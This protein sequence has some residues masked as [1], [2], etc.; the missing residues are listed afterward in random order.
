MLEPLNVKFIVDPLNGTIPTRATSESAA[1]DFYASHD[2]TIP[3]FGRAAIGT[4][5]TVCWNN[6]NAYLQLFSRSGLF[7]NFGITCEGGVIDYDFQQP[8][9]VL[10][11]NNTADCYEVKKGDRI[12]QGIFLPICPVERYIYV[13]DG[14]GY[15]CVHDM[16]SNLTRVGGLGSTGK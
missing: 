1:L 7:K 8:I 13:E 15:S 16:A 5:V 9:S 14:T 11:Q 6:S 12:C 2:F 4:D 3:G 10:L